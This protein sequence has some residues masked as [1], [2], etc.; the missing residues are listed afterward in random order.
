[1][2]FDRQ[3]GERRWTFGAA[4]RRSAGLYLGDSGDGLVFAGSPAGFLQAV[5][6][7]SGRPRWTQAVTTGTVFAP[8]LI[9]AGLVAAG[10]ADRGTPRRG[11]IAAFDVRTGRERWRRTF[12]PWT[13]VRSSTGAAGT[14][15]ACGS[16]VILGSEEGTLYGLDPN[17]GQVRWVIP[18]LDA[19]PDHGEPPV[20]DYRPLACGE[21]TLIAGSLTGQ[22]VAYEVQTRRE[23]WRRAPEAASVA[24]GLS[25]DAE[26]VFVPY[27]SGH[28]L[29][30]SLADGTER[31][32]IGGRS[33]GLV[34]T[35][36]V[37]DSRLLVA[38]SGAGFMAF[39]R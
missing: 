23:R 15:V 21:Q 6:A 33:A 18:P 19:R 26:S 34:W 39:R 32:R 38:G 1:V 25:T 36:L 30:L 31:W 4:E 11:G 28:L 7:D 12:L 5:D 10:F 16:V 24:F 22:V 2:A 13:G 8:A 27:L 37:H 20:R 29:A 35:P 9:G 3:T 17:G 14:P